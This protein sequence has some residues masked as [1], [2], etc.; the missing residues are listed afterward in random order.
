GP[1]DKAALFAWVSD[2]LDHNDSRVQ[3]IGQRAV[4]WA[5]S[6]DPKDTT[7]VRVLIQLSYG[8]SVANS[9]SNGFAAAAELGSGSVE[10]PRVGGGTSG[11]G[12]MF[13]GN[14]GAQ[15]N[16]GYAAR[17]H[18][19]VGGPVVLSTDR[20]ALGYLR[21]LTS[22]L[23][24]PSSPGAGVGKA[25][26]LTYASL[27]LPLVLFRLR[28]ERHRIRRQT[29]LL[30]RVLC[31]HMSVRSC[32]ARLDELG[33]SIV[34]D[35]P[36]IAADAATRLTA[37]VAASFA[38][39][40]EMA[41]LE[42][43]RQVHVQ[44]SVGGRLAALL[45]ILQPWVGNIELRH[46]AGDGCDGLGPVALSR[47]SLVVLRCMLYLTVKAGVDALPGIQELWMALVG[48]DY[49][50]NMWLAMRYLTGL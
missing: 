37:A 9:V 16:G 44:G 41:I 34:S 19:A 29:L 38:A 12:L 7:M 45:E 27:I 21:A 42:C 20:I 22:I 24:A 49:E 33:P 15:S 48:G 32:L 11:L 5:V 3:R 1:R 50:Q 30:L 17:H 10:S 6:A 36:A 28:S 14:E 23:L 39:H 35:I 25:L 26:S 43:V 13:G 40:S 47:D 2:A 8:L 18:N 31:S 46:V 4:E